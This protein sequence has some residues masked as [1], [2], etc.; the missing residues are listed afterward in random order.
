MEAGRARAAGL[1]E[2]GLARRAA[3][4]CLGAAR[5]EATA[6]RRVD[7]ARNLAMQDDAVSVL[8][9][10]GQRDRLRRE[11]RTGIGMRAVTGDQRGRA[12][13]HQAAKIHDGDVIADMHGDREVS[14]KQLAREIRA[15]ER[16]MLEFARNL[17][18]E[19]AARTRDQ[20][21][22]LRKRAFGVA[23]HAD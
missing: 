9:A 3:G 4:L 19:K 20:L 12:V 15:L 6:R 5:A 21:G 22:E 23:A 18:F 2:G 11:Q 17:E 7:R 14:T 1:E 10:L 16:Q 13:L 8:Q